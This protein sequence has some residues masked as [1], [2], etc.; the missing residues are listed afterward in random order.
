MFAKSANIYVARAC[1]LLVL[2]LLTIVPNAMTTNQIAQF[3]PLS[4]GALIVLGM[5]V[6]CLC[7]ARN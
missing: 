5:N 3:I 2:D 7:L 1:S 6:H 4:V